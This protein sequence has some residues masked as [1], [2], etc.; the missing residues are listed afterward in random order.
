VVC[1]ND[2]YSKPPV[3][4]RGEKAAEHFVDDML[5]EEEYIEN[6]LNDA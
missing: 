6:I 1:T 4:Y 5:K 2:N 3:L